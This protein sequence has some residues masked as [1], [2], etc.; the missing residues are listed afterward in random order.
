M[1]RNNKTKPQT[2]FAIV[3]LLG[4][5][6]IFEQFVFRL[7]LC[8]HFQNTQHNSYFCSIYF[9]QNLWDEAP[10]KTETWMIVHLLFTYLLLKKITSVQM[11]S[12]LQ[13]TLYTLLRG[14]EK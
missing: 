7:L 6:L 2:S 12:D 9:N 4:V 5:F 3:L 10:P 11:K 1:G 13:L 14:R 8:T